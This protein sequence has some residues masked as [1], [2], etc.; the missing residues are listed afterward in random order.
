MS[1]SPRRASGGSSRRSRRSR[2]SARR[3]ARRSSTLSSPFVPGL[4]LARAFYEEVVAPVVADV[5]HSAALLGSGSDVLGF[6]TARSTDHGWGPRLQLFVA[7]PV[8]EEV[9]DAVEA[10][11]PES[12]R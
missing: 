4:E 1:A 6:D 12:F 10:A 5:P 8:L 9:A 7:D 11:L 2:A 3:C